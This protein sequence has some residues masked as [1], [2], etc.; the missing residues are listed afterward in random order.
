LNEDCTQ[1]EVF[2]QTTKPLLQHVLDGYNATVFA[3]GATGCGKTYTI[4]GTEDNPGIIYRTLHELYRLMDSMAK[5]IL[6]ETSVSY[7]EVYNENI[8]DLFARNST[9]NLDIREDDARVVVA[10]LSEIQPKDLSHVMNLLLRGNEHRSQAYTE[11]N[12]TSSRSHAVL[13]IHIRQQSRV[14]MG[15]KEIKISTLSIIDLAG[16]ERA[17]ATNNRGDRLQEGANINRSLLALGNCINALCAEKP[18]HIPFR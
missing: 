15:P 1:L 2:E 13:Q 7:L 9:Q 14:P 18:N 16:S 10:G 12:A 6:V 8:R 4:T 5:D 11:A 17:S 3:Y